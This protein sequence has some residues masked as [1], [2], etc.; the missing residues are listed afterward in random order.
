MTATNF[1]NF[2]TQLQDK[3]HELFSKIEAAAPPL[4]PVIDKIEQFFD[5]IFSRLDDAVSQSSAP[6]ASLSGATDPATLSSH[7]AEIQ[8]LADRTATDSWHYPGLDPWPGTELHLPQNFHDH[9]L[10]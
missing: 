10:V 9:W 6:A 2:I 4:V 1:H 8:P 3:F 5:H 7:S